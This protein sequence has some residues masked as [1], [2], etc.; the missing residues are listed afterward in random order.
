MAPDVSRRH[1]LEIAGVGGAFA[2]LRSPLDSPQGTPA[3]AWPGDA[4]TGWFDRPM[5][6]V[7]LTLVENDPGRFDPQFWLDYFRRVRA[8]AACLSAGGIVAYYPTDVPLH[9]RS[10]WLGKDDPFGTLVA[11][12]RALGMHVIARIDP[13]AAREDVRTAHPDWIA[14]TR[15]GEPYRHWANPDLWVTCALG[16]YNFEFMDRVQREIVTRY[17]VDGIFANRWAGSGDCFC[18]HCQRNFKTAT[19]WTCRA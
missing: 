5:R 4:L 8:D 13:H 17:K 12:C 2:T 18:A 16:P 14:V 11:G 19:G 1:F 9:H 6:W 10:A 3:P 15:T 7:Q